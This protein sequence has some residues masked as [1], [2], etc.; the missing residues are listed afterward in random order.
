MAVIIMNDDEA[1]FLRR[2]DRY[3]FENKISSIPIESGAN[4]NRPGH[5]YLH[6]EFMT[7]P[8]PK[9]YPTRANDSPY[10]RPIDGNKMMKAENIS[11]IQLYKFNI[12][13]RKD[14]LNG[15]PDE[16]ILK[17]VPY[18]RLYIPKNLGKGFKV[19]KN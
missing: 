18:F 5:A 12:H 4:R 3:E 2:V 13:Y 15:H 7:G 17:N 11:T 9:W 19:E 6:Y 8:Q 14:Q 10:G 16:P 1:Q